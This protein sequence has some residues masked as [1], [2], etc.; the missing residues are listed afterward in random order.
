M[1]LYRHTTVAPLST[2]YIIYKI[3]QSTMNKSEQDTSLLAY[4]PS[5]TQDNKTAN[6]KIN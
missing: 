5:Y 3:L 6:K 1:L 2:E 4:L